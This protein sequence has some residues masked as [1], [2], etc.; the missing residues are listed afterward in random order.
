MMAKWGEKF[1]PVIAFLMFL[2]FEVLLK[3]VHVSR[4]RGTLPL[5][6]FFF[7]TM[8]TAE[9]AATEAAPSSVHLCSLVCKTLAGSPCIFNTCAVI[10]SRFA[11]LLC[12]G[13]SFPE[14]HASSLLACKTQ[15]LWFKCLQVA[16]KF[17]NDPLL[18]NVIRM[19]MSQMTVY[20]GSSLR[21]S[22]IMRQRCNFS[23]ASRLFVIQSGIL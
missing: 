3:L 12:R 10:S 13:G 21:K 11:H 4:R 17:C 1:K 15:K 6:C 16:A 18:I 5:K 2:R 9:A 20:P 8:P 7:S 14:V 19:Y 23:Q 22:K